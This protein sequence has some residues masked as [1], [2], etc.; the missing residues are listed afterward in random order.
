MLYDDG[1]KK[2]KAKEAKHVADILEL[3][4]T[5]CSLAD[6]NMA[7]LGGDTR[8]AAEAKKGRDGEGRRDGAEFSRLSVGLAVR[9][10]IDQ[11]R[12]RFS[13]PVL[14]TFG[15]GL[16]FSSR[17]AGLSLFLPMCVAPSTCRCLPCLLEPQ[18]R[19]TGASSGTN[20]AF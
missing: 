9:E 5:F 13:F 12:C 8:A 16:F 14:E 10:V 20:A 1:P 4:Q 19:T 3:S 11:P 6:A 15:V 2:L 17:K 18:P 7:G